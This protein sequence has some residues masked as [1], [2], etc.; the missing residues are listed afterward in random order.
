MTEEIIA[1]LEL[2]KSIKDYIE[3]YRLT[4]A[5]MT[6]PS[7][8]EDA[9]RDRIYQDILND[10][11]NVDSKSKEREEFKATWAVESYIRLM[12]NSL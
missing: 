6:R 12:L 9:L 11:P 2:N 7:Y 8:R 4:I 5:D 1:K 3:T 10:N